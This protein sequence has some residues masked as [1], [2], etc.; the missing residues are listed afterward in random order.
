ML[1]GSILHSKLGGEPTDFVQIQIASKGKRGGGIIWGRAVVNVIRAVIEPVAVVV[2]MVAVVDVIT[3]VVIEA[4]AWGSG[5]IPGS[6][7]WR[8]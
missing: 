2:A 5:Q 3:E 8:R 7:A 1:L 6:E 4:R